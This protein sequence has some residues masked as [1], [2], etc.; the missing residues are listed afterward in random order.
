MNYRI[1][2]KLQKQPLVAAGGHTRSHRKHVWTTPPGKGGWIWLSPTPYSYIPAQ[3]KLHVKNYRCRHLINVYWIHN[4]HIVIF[5]R[6]SHYQFLKNNTSGNSPYPL[7]FSYSRYWY[8]CL[9][10][11]P[12]SPSSCKCNLFCWGTDLPCSNFLTLARLPVTGTRTRLTIQRVP[13]LLQQGLVWR[14]APRDWNL[15][16]QHHSMG[17]FYIQKQAERKPVF[18]QMHET[19]MFTTLELLLSAMFTVMQRKTVWRR[20]DWR[21]RQALQGVC[22]GGVSERDKETQGEAKTE[23]FY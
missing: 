7:N 16:H 1:N 14:S 4:K 18:L 15:A 9:L 6:R 17:V 21:Q 8:L 22:V 2:S 20:R 13:L 12:P 5:C 3:E 23:H 11:M 10:N 19:I